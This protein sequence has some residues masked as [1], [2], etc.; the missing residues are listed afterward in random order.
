MRCSVHTCQNEGAN[1]VVV[2]TG[3]MLGKHRARVR[4]QLPLVACLE[5]SHPGPFWATVLRMM[6]RTFAALLANCGIALPH[7]HH[8]RVRFVRIRPARPTPVPLTVDAR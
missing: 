4:I 6:P 7:L 2:I 5:H 1:R 8:T 3:G